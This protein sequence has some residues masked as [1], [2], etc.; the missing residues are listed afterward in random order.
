MGKTEVET[1]ESAAYLNAANDIV[2]EKDDGIAPGTF[3][4]AFER[5]FPGLKISQIIAGMK[6]VH[7][8]HNGKNYRMTFTGN[9]NPLTRITGFQQCVELQEK[10]VE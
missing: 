4:V 7:F 3:R 1:E 10:E 8:S 5:K 9:A 2:L 6:Q